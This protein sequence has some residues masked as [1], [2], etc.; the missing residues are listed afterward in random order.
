MCSD[1]RNMDHSY[2]R[3]IVHWE[4]PDKKKKEEDT[5]F[6]FSREKECDCKGA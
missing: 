3:D 6:N 5:G 2:H 1:D 4:Y